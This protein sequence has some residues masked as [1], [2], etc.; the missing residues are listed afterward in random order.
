MNDMIEIHITKCKNDVK[1]GIKIIKYYTKGDV[2]DGLTFMSEQQRD[3]A[4]E[5]IKQLLKG[6]NV[7]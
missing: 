6:S 1:F 4:F 5:E 7:E 3:A 2:Y